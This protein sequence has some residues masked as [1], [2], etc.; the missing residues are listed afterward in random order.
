MAQAKAGMVN[1]FYVK[2]EAMGGQK[3]YEFCKKAEQSDKRFHPHETNKKSRLL[4][5]D[6]DIKDTLKEYFEKL[7]NEENERGKEEERDCTDTRRQR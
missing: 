7:L 2:L 5:G 3:I 6:K 1:E 4:S